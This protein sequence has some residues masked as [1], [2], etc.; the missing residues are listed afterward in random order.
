MSAYRVKQTRR[1]H[2]GMSVVDPKQTPG[3]TLRECNRAQQWGPGRSA[4]LR[5]CGGCFSPPT[6]AGFSSHFR[7]PARFQIVVGREDLILHVTHGRVL[8]VANR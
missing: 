2:C 3:R 4:A 6:G 5:P 1:G 7:L 8:P